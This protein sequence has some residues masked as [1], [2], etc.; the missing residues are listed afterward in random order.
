[1][2]HRH[3]RTDLVLEIPYPNMSGR[4]DRSAQVTAADDQPKNS[5]ACP[6]WSEHSTIA[7]EK[8]SVS[9]VILVEG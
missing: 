7:P 8:S 2:V 5:S 9:M 6:K 4:G 1:M 3:F